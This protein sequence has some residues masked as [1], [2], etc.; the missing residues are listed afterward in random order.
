MG[1]KRGGLFMGLGGVSAELVGN[2][3][4]ARGV[5]KR[6]AQRK[7]DPRVCCWPERQHGDIAGR[8]ERTRVSTPLDCGPAP[9]P[10][11]C[12]HS[13]KPTRVLPRRLSFNT[14]AAAQV[15]LTLHLPEDGG[16][17]GPAAISR[18][19]LWW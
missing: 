7:S 6:G 5:W 19:S 1:G 12:S 16:V 9:D 18:A 13:D 3:G 2:Q 15:H 8:Q 10:S 14:R 4:A 11:Q 17:G